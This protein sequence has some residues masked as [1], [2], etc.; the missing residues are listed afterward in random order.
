MRALEKLLLDDSVT[1]LSSTE[2]QAAIDMLIHKAEVYLIGA[3]KRKKTEEITHYEQKI[4]QF[5]QPRC[6]P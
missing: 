3:R 2:R 4:A 5:S 1:K 6:T